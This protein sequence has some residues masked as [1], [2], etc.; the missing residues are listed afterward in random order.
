MLKIALRSPDSQHKAMLL[1]LQERK[2]KL[3]EKNKTETN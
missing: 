2:N 1:I 3:D